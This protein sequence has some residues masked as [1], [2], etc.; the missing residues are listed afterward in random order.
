MDENSNSSG[1]H[2]WDVPSSTGLDRDDCVI[3]GNLPAD[4]AAVTESF[5]KEGSPVVVPT[6]LLDQLVAR[7]P[8]DYLSL[9]SVF[10]H[11]SP[12]AVY[13][14][15]Q[16]KSLFLKWRIVSG[17]GLYDDQVG[18]RFRAWK[19]HPGQYAAYEF[20]PNAEGVDP[21]SMWS[22]QLKAQAA[23]ERFNI[24]EDWDPDFNE[25]KGDMEI[26]FPPLGGKAAD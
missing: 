14:S 8:H 10:S 24:A 12:S 16:G 21:N 2:S 11:Q 5:L 18:L 4:Y 15:R 17:D 22:K 25:F 3:L 26:P 19:D 13:W 9:I 1:G 7:Y 23:A 20:F 6:K